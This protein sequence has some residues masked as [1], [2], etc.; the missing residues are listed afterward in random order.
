MTTTLTLRFG[1]SGPDRLSLLRHLA[2]AEGFAGVPP[3]SLDIDHAE[4]EPTT[5]WLDRYVHSS[6]GTVIANWDRH[7]KRHLASQFDVVNVSIP[8][9][10]ASAQAVLELLAR[11][12]FEVAT[13]RTLHT[14]WLH[15]EY[16]PPPFAPHHPLL[17]WACAFRGSGHDRL[18][19]R[20]WL[21]DGP[22]QVLRGPEGSDITLVQFHSL[23]ADADTALA[24][25]RP[26]H[27]RMGAGPRG[28]FVREPYQF[29]HE[30]RGLYDAAQRLQRVIVHGR[31][32]SEGEMRDACVA[33]RHGGMDPG[34]PIERVAYV[35]TEG[36]APARRHLHELWLRELECWAII[37]G[38]EVCL[39]KDYAP[40]PEPPAWVLK[41]RGAGS[42]Q[43]PRV[44]LS[45]GQDRA[46]GAAE[47]SPG[48][49][50]RDVERSATSAGPTA[51]VVSPEEVEFP[52]GCILSQ[53]RY[54]IV[55][56]LRGGPDRGQYRAM[57]MGDLPR[58]PALVTL[59]PPQRESAEALWQKLAITADGIMRLRHIG[60][61]TGP[62]GERYD[63]LI[64]DEPAGQPVAGH[65]S[66]PLAPEVARRLALGVARALEDAH[67]YGWVVQGIRPELIYAAEGSG[68]LDFTGLAPRCEVFWATAEERCYGVPPCFD[69]TYLAPEVIAG[70]PATQAAD[71]FSLTAVLAH[72]VSG[73]HPFMGEGLQQVLS[74]AT[75]QRRRFRGPSVF[76]QIIERGLAPDA[77]KR[78]PLAEWVAMLGA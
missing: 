15:D 47:R 62:A 21:D 16:D 67:R 29:T 69:H 40:R 32:V 25:A 76:A 23:V 64:E 27:E 46:E 12:P 34:H 70:R 10:P 61:L 24:Q 11:L 50:Q 6:T 17:G 2:A 55:A 65:L 78:P 77:A 35:F 68:G 20:R 56:H 14:K 57:P 8:G 58:E 45:S 22:W 71:V 38:R 37:D 74:L 53:G 42:G 51:A 7:G 13:F 44:Q 48:A 1:V 73:E 36:E 63:A 66:L 33:R 59:G 75:G 43:G 18:L 72:W 30:I 52:V 26:G 28:G 3:E 31:E 4:R 60:P 39:D 54:R 9:F 41:E 19:S 5:D 49:V